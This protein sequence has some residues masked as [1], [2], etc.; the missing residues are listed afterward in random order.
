M[1]NYLILSNL[2]NLLFIIIGILMAAISVL[3]LVI[4]KL[5]NRIEKYKMQIFNSLNK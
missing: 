1:E 3:S 4:I 5:N 2:N